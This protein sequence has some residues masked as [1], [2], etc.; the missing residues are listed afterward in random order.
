MNQ[1]KARKLFNFY[2]DQNTIL[3]LNLNR[4]YAMI[5]SDVMSFNSYDDQIAK[6]KEAQK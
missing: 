6:E 2:R 5:Q 4:C 1:E 3:T